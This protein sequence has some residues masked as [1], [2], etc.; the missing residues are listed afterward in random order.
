M[1]KC[2]NCGL[3]FVSEVPDIVDNYA[4]FN[5]EWYYNELAGDKSKFTYGLDLMRSWLKTTGRKLENQKILDVGCGDGYFLSLCLDLGMT[6][7]GLD[8]SP[9]VA[10]YAE[11]RGLKVFSDLK[12]IKDTFDIITLFDV[13]EHM[14][15]PLQE[16]SQLTQLLN[17][18]GIIFIETP[19]KCL[20]DFYLS[21]LELFG[22]ASNNRVSKEHLQ[23]F[24]DKSLRILINR[25]MLNSIYSKNKT[26][27]SWGVSAG[28]N[29]YISNIGIKSKPLNKLFANLVRIFLKANAFG[30]NK[31]IILATN[32]AAH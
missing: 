20:A 12:E 24:T 1:T 17:D 11:R 15:D 27:L 5:L 16:L 22:I 19:R 31:A 26:S 28:L 18:K 25:T 10:S 29:Q 2:L 6:A 13:L 14:T 23:L 32:T 8:I 30:K 3:L 21:I 7:Y 9:E 4:D